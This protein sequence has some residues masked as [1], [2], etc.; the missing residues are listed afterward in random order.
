MHELQQNATANSGLIQ[1]E[2]LVSGAVYPVIK[3]TITNYN[4]LI[5]KPLPQDTRMEA[6]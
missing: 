4:R 5:P 3:E 1:I 6:M 2:E